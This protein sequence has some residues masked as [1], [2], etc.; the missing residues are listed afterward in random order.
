MSGAVFSRDENRIL[1]W[2]L[3]NTA[4]LWSVRWAMRS[5]ND[6]RFLK[7]LCREKLVGAPVE[8]R[9]NQLPLRTLEGVRHID[10]RDTTVAPILRGREGEDVCAGEPTTWDT[11]VSLVKATR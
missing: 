3:D 7:D 1:T 6:P 8:A 9:G 2:S 5:V 10:S 11:L 4:R